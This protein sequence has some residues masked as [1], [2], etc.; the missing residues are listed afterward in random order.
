MTVQRD[1][2][3]LTAIKGLVIQGSADVFVSR[4][5]PSMTVIA[6]KP[7]D[8]ITEIRGGTLRISQKPTVMAGRGRGSMVMNNVGSGSVQIFHNV[9]VGQFTPGDMVIV[10]GVAMVGQIV[11]VEITLPDLQSA[12][13]EGSGDLRL[14]DLHQDALDLAITGSGTIRATGEVIRLSAEVTGSGDVK[15]KDLRASVTELQVSG[16]GDIKAQA[17]QSLKARVTG[18]GD[19]KVWGNPSKRDTRVTGSGEIQ[20]K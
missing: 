11:K 17:L 15:A 5:A 1:T 18:S 12:C 14:E 7:E 9:Q 6:E 20:I 19:I 4:G 16:S 2:R 13:I 10:N 8:V 3:Q